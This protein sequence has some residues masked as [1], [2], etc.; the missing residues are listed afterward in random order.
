MSK[1]REEAQNMYDPSYNAKVQAMKNQ[2]AQN[3]QALEQQKGGLNQT[4]D[5][6]VKNAN[7]NNRLNKNATSNAMLGRGLANSSIA[8]SGL[9][10][11]DAKN[12]RIVGDI[13]RGRLGDLKNI[14]QQKALLAQNMNNTLG[15]MA[16]DR[17]TE[18]LSLMQQFESRDWDRNFKN[19]Q[20]AQEKALQD[21]QLAYQYAQLAQQRE[22]ASGYGGYGGEEDNGDDA[23]N[24]FLDSFGSISAMP[25]SPEKTNQF[26][27][28]KQMA[29]M[30]SGRYG[31]DFGNLNQEIDRYLY[32]EGKR[33]G[34]IKVTSTPSKKKSGGF[35]NNLFKNGH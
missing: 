28:L 30:Y 31:T 13:E 35:W 14:D 23:Y 33:V 17:E 29:N 15:Q 27:A 11:N 25:N 3:Q 7:L 2:L 32:T 24:S 26:N 34:D 8:V 10:E 19:Q 20:L 6:Q 4:Y 22:L 21:A 16:G 9:A 18:L 12:T 1:Y 5:M